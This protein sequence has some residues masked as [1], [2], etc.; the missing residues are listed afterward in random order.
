MFVKNNDF[1]I[2]DI[3]TYV[4]NSTAKSSKLSSTKKD[5]VGHIGELFHL[6]F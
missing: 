1:E 2:N 4:K 6:V 5:F 3:C